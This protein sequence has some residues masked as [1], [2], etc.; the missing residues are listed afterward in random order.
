MKRSQPHNHSGR[1]VSSAI[2]FVLACVL[3]M[4]TAVLPLEVRGVTTRITRQGQD[5]HLTWDSTPGE[6][7]VVQ[8]RESLAPD[9]FWITLANSYAARA[10]G[11]TTTFV[12]G[13]ILPLQLQASMPSQQLSAEMRAAKLAKARA[14]AQK[15][16]AYLK[17]L[18]DEAV[19][20]SRSFQSSS[21]PPPPGGT[22]NQPTVSVQT[23]SGST[24]FY[25]VLLAT[26][27][28]KLDVFGVEQNSNRNQLDVLDNDSD[29]LAGSVL[30]DT[31]YAPANGHIESDAT[32]DGQ[33][34]PYTP[35]A[36]FFGIDQFSYRVENANRG[37]ATAQAYVFVNQSGNSAP[38]REM[39]TQTLAPNN[40][41]WEL[42]VLAAATDA[43]GDPVT[44]ALATTPRLG[45]VQIEAPGLVRYTRGWNL[46]GEDH[47]DIF[48]TDG[49][50][51]YVKV[52]VL[53][54]QQDSDSD[55]MPDE[56]ESR[57]GLNPALNDAN[58]DGDFDGVP[59]LAE[60]R[61]QKDPAESDNPLHL[62]GF[63]GTLSDFIHIV[64]KLNPKTQ[65]P[66]LFLLVNNERAASVFLEQN[67][68][69]NW[70]VLW[71]SSTVPNGAYL[72][73]L[74]FEHIPANN[75]SAR[76]V[77]L[78]TPRNFVVENDITF[79][80]FYDVFES[81]LVVSGTINIPATDYRIELYDE[82]GNFLDFDEGTPNGGTFAVAW[83]TT[84]FSENIRAE[85]ILTIPQAG[86]NL[87][88][89][90]SRIRRWFSKE[91]TGGIGDKFAVAW[92]WHDYGSSFQNRRERMMAHGVIDVIGNPGLENEYALTPPHNVPLSDSAFRMDEPWQKNVLLTSMEVS[93]AN[94]FWFGHGS[95]SDLAGNVKK[96]TIPSSEVQDLL[97]NRAHI[98]TGFGAGKNL[99]PYRF[100]F[101][102]GC[103]TYSTHW[104]KAFG[105]E[106]N[107][108]RSTK[109]MQDYINASREPRAFVGW[110]DDA[111]V[112]ASHS[113]ESHD[114]MALAL[115]RFFN[116]WMA[117]VP[118]IDCM[119][120]FEAGLI[121]GGF[122]NHNTWS[123]SACQDLTRSGQVP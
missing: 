59:N 70:F 86:G 106:F 109:R 93:T 118:L 63:P 8:Y 30:I 31:I 42:N 47:F 84:S 34:F 24:G 29:P 108:R 54:E 100:V 67:A 15:A 64:P 60:F 32:V 89:S 119:F 110:T 96:S 81:L 13:G 17:Q 92:G 95:W 107:P 2:R 35:N 85:I 66:N 123:I 120:E 3:M 83:N 116:F 97:G 11:P 80:P 90:P 14:D 73:Q 9:S 36:G 103:C 37:L 114:N 7:F 33:V 48:L 52:P 26:P 53:I 58:A 87:I 113:D 122:P 62:D 75:E 12:H 104:A 16:I 115:G 57:N 82:A 18:L 51:G 112:P 4:I 111:F 38:A 45:T 68:G 56:W 1:S 117:D 102:Y 43:D 65:R 71:D 49:R 5:V 6:A 69:G 121:D 88:G 76:V 40:Y 79:E 39:I 44:I 61:L 50:G 10:D 72:L 77:A 22:N 19:L 41:S 78:G 21:G 99:H 94:F 46:F 98:R 101:L 91:V 27:R 55:F 105:I 25:R 23:G 20:R 74:G 28:A